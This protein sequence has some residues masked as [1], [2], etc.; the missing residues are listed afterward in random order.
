MYEDAEVRCG[1]DILRAGRAHVSPACVAVAGRSWRLS[2]FVVQP[3]PAV[4]VVCLPVAE[5]S[6][7]VSDVKGTGKFGWLF[8]TGVTL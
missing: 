3:L 2:A 7:E 6:W 1:N 5:L 8:K 4:S